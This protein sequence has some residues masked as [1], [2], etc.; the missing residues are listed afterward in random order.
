MTTDHSQALDRLSC[1][2]LTIIRGLV[3][4]EAA[5]MIRM[6]VED[7]H[8]RLRVTVAPSDFGK[9]VGRHGQNIEAIRYL[10]AAVGYKLKLPCCTNV[11]G[12]DRICVH[13]S[14]DDPDPRRRHRGARMHSPGDSG[15]GDVTH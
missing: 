3:D 1:V 7:G 14:V 15:R 11:E 9:V 8:T 13:I 10:A 2:V 12:V 6:A 4:D 5:V